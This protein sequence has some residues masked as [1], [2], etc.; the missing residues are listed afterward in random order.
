MGRLGSMIVWMIV[1][2]LA[3][4]GGAFGYLMFTGPTGDPSVYGTSMFGAMVAAAIGATV[5]LIY[6]AVRRR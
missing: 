2:A 1:L 4:G 3:F 6:G 5:G